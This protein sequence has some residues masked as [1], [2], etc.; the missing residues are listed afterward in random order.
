MARILS[1]LSAPG[2]G[3]RTDAV[4]VRAARRLAGL[5]HDVTDLAIRDLPADALLWRDVGHPAVAAAL[6]RVE[7][8]DGLIVTSA[9]YQSSFTA[10]V[11]AFLDLLPMNGLRDTFVLPFMVGGSAGHVLALDYA[12]RPVLQSLAPTH[13]A[14]GRY[15]LASGVLLDAEGRVGFEESAA[16]DIDR[17]TADFAAQLG[18]PDRELR[19]AS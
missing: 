12:L 11:K 18:G 19:W 8:A 16:A 15:I 4:G 10:P 1:V 2:P 13:V 3:S 14:A 9:V 7:Q 5:G 17:A 6:A